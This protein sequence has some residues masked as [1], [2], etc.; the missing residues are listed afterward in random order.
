MMAVSFVL[1]G[2]NPKYTIGAIE[3]SKLMPLIYPG[4]EM[5]IWIEFDTTPEAV[6]Q[7]LS[8]NGVKVHNKYKKIAPRMFQRMLIHDEP[9]VDRY[10]VRDCDSRISMRE[11]RCVD[12]W[13]R[14]GTLLHTIHDHPYHLAGPEIMGGL[15]GLWKSACRYQ[16]NMADLML[17][18][19]V[20]IED[21]WGSDQTFLN[22]EIWPKFNWSRSQHGKALQITRLPGEPQG[23]FCGEVI[24]EHG[25][26]NFEH[27]AMKLRGHL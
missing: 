16:F 1:W 7:Q 6:I 15:W 11:R 2:N 23:A 26:P 19:Q 3:N 24:D 10:I 5:H 14:M 25:K 9:N 20:P 27:R 8:K 17:K 13:M 18:A 22:N 4:W 12:E 21:K